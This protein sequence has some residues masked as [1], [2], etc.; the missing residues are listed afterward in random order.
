MGAQQGGEALPMA[1]RTQR[2]GSGTGIRAAV[3]P[4]RSP[5][6]HLHLDFCSEREVRSQQC[7]LPSLGR[8]RQQLGAASSQS[9]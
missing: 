4:P 2:A 6:L 1:M 3:H 7:I 9:A 5:R 8:C